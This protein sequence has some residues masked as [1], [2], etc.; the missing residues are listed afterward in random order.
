MA[1]NQSGILQALGWATLNSFWQMGLLWAAFLLL[2]YLFKPSS[3]GK[4]II[5]VS[6]VLSG[7]ALFVFTFFSFYYNGVQEIS[8][9]QITPPVASGIL[10]Q[11]LTAAS[12]TYLALILIPAWKVYRNWRFLVTIRKT[13]LHKAPLKN[14]LFVRKISSI[15]GIKKP[16]LIYLSELVNS[17]VTI[18]FLKPVILLPLAAITQLSPLQ[19][20]AVLIHELTHIRRHDYLLNL[21]LTAI[22]VILYFNPFIRFFI[23]VVE[24]ERENCCDE[25]VL[26]FE[27]DKISY[28][29]AL[30]QLEK[31][32]HAS[33]ELAM[34]A[35]HK[36]HLLARIEK[37]V[38]VKRKMSVNPNHFFAS[39]VAFVILFAVNSLIIAGKQKVS[40]SPATF[41]FSQPVSYLPSQQNILNAPHAAS[42]T[43]AAT[44][45]KVAAT[46]EVNPVNEDGGLTVAPAENTNMNFAALD[47]VDASLTN[48]QKA[49]VKNTLSSTKKV[50]RSRWKE[51][52]ATMADGM[53]SAEKIDAHNEYMQ[54][55]EKLNWD[56]IE[57]NMKARYEDLDWMKINQ[58]L[59]MQVAAAQL[60]SLK[61]NYLAALAELEQARSQHSKTEV[62]PVPDAS[63]KQ[64]NKMQQELEKRIKLI[65]IKERKIIRL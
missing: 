19:M 32:N 21:L 27:Y 43:I 41:E 4:Y 1:A 20:E 29:S 23:S 18:G 46:S 33:T 44:P 11:I 14:R 52:E 31:N 57:Q 59:T 64:L 42:S 8:Y 63:L 54:Q 30:L 15:L 49:Q 12:I 7:A 40:L 55:I 17:P 53:N 28:A 25:L 51:V 16:V 37:I 13:S 9:L 48:D 39:V 5:A 2:T 10:P 62:L 45:S 65:T 22:R 50:L 3:N 6:C 60:D 38:G 56:R 58:Q 34:A 24:A 35:T 47:D 61:Q 36:N 26:Q